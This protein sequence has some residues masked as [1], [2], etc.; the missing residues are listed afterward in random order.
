MMWYTECGKDGDVV[1][2]SRVRLARNLKGIPFPARADEKQQEE[3]L[4][5]CKNA[6]LESGSTLADTVKYIDLSVMQDYEKQAIA[7]RHLISPQMMDSR[8]K[9]GLLL[10]DDNRLSILLNEEDHIRIQAMAAGFDLDACFSLADRVDDLIEESV[11]YAFDEQIGYLTCCPTN[12]GTGMRASVMV[13]LPGLT[14]SGTINQM[15]DSLS[16]LGVT[17]RGLFGEGSKATGYLYQISNQLTLG[18]A[19]EDIL[20][21][22][23]QIVESV[24]GKE[25]EMRTRLYNTDKYKLEDRLMRSYGILSHAV[26]LSSEEAMKRLSD[27]RMGIELGIIKNIKLEQLNEVTYEILPANIML[28]YNLPDANERD[29]KRAEIVRE[30]MCS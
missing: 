10:S 15:I 19:E 27:V 12:A 23:K 17:V 20:E 18:A 16:Q 25:R 22:F 14:I 9:R 1:L 2:S 3:V 7:E 4:T 13:H 8:I 11:E 24:I 5:R 6:V 21:K 28:K 26:L 30:R 29:L